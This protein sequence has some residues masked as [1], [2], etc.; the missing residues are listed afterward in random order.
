MFLFTHSSAA[1]SQLYVSIGIIHATDATL[2]GVIEYE[3]LEP[4]SSINGIRPML[5]KKKK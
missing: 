2:P 4:S 1:K 5:K 3:I